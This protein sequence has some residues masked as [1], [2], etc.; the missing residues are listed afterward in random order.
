MKHPRTRTLL[1]LS[2]L[3]LI[4]CGDGG[5][6]PNVQPPASEVSTLSR[7]SGDGQTFAPGSTLPDS[8]GVRAADREGNPVSGVVVTW[9]V[10]TGEGDVRP[11]Q[12]TTGTDGLARTA[13]TLGP[14]PGDNRVEARITDVE[15]VIFRATAER[16]RLVSVGGNNQIGVMYEFLSDSLSVRL[17]DVDGFPR[18]G[19]A[20]QF[21]VDSGEG[22]LPNPDVTDVNG[23][24]STRWRLGLVAGLQ[25]AFAHVSGEFPVEFTAHATGTLSTFQADT[26]SASA[27]S[28]C[29]L[30]DEGRAY[31]WGHNIFGSLGTGNRESRGIPTLVQTSV[32]FSQISVGLRE[33]CGLD[34]F[35]QA[36]CW[37][38][39]IYGN[40]GDG[41]NENRTTP[42]PVSGGHRFTSISQ[43]EATCGLE[44]SQEVYCWGMHFSNVPTKIDLGGPV[45]LV[46]SGGSRGCATRLDGRVICWTLGSGVSPVP[47]DDELSFR[48]IGISL[49]GGSTGGFACGLTMEDQPY[50]WG[51]NFGGALG[52]GSFEDGASVEPKPVVGGFAFAGI[53]VGTEHSCGW[54]NDGSTYCWGGNET[55]R[56][57]GALGDGT[58]QSRASPTR[59]VG[60]L[61]FRSVEAG[62]FHS[63]GVA[64]SSEVY[65]WG[66]GA[67]LLGIG[68]SISS[69][70]TSPTKVL[71][72]NP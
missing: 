53:A 39:N 17:T 33:T 7:A 3:A 18:P 22:E 32:R 56:G 26:I 19:V 55:G 29:A 72:V 58:T 16:P 36:Y 15:P 23:V 66:T 24:A 1:S 21:V 71:I 25:R 50:C 51:S 48:S 12:S 30:N 49:G 44:V 34:Q 5:T 8:I 43:G 45:S 35:G 38:S 54:T 41:T 52:T 20:V 28:T 65:C 46:E 6:A 10:L 63:C 61:L 57:E 9:A 59:V 4:S 60:G 11:T 67:L 27:S 13:W 64:T 37:G 70:L 31:C 42:V 62:G 14:H 69:A 40:V 2:I 68:R 47:L